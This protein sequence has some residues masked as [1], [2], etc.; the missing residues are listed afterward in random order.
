M[1]GKKN[2]I[3]SDFCKKI[4][5]LNAKTDKF[6]LDYLR[7]RNI[8]KIINYEYIKITEQ[9]KSILDRSLYDLLYNFLK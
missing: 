6:C 2:M 7:A 5:F 8:D 1:P 4:I 3:G 9:P